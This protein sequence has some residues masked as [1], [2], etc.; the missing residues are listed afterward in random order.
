MALNK[1]Q[2]EEL[3]YEA[4]RAFSG[5]VEG[6]GELGFRVVSNKGVSAIVF[7]AGNTSG[8][9][10]EIAVCDNRLTEAYDLE[11][12][13]AW[14]DVIRA[15]EGRRCAPRK[16]AGNWPTIGFDLAG[17]SSFFRQARKLRFGSLPA[18]VIAQ[19][20][21]GKEG[22]TPE[23][24]R[25]AEARAELASRRPTKRN[26][27]I[28]L[29]RKAGVSTERWSIRRDGTLVASPRSNPNYCY[30]WAFGGKDEPALACL[31]HE[32]LTVDAGR[33]KFSGNLRQAAAR[34]EAI[35]QTAGEDSSVRKRAREQAGRAKQLDALIQ[36][37]AD[38][39][40]PL[41]VIVNEGQ[42]RSEENLGKESSVVK[43][44]YLDPQ[45]WSVEF[46]DAG[47]GDF[48]VVR[49]DRQVVARQVE[50]RE[51]P[52]ESEQ[53]GGVGDPI[54]GAQASRAF[55]DQH[56]APGSDQATRVPLSGEAYIRD[57][58]VRDACLY[59]AA[60]HC[61]FCNAPG[62]R[63]AD[64]RTYLETHH[65]VPLAEGGADREWN[66]VALCPNDHREAHYGERSR[67]IR[68]EMQAFLATVYAASTNQGSEGSSAA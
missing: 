28:D 41:R 45:S 59:R 66:V 23:Q 36:A 62:F 6:L 46:Y 1:G 56:S 25:D 19:L 7:W 67:Q 8:N 55:V 47:I 49:Q 26:A 21:V 54:P 20:R 18:D 12:V 38:R 24:V 42:M 52:Q 11:T 57:R 58:K 15:S 35:A 2:K 40:K 22:R 61:E 17:A 44:R 27:V 39:E 14:I 60:G 3:E 51:V 16:E 4:V 68:T 9:A 33:I 10:A 53:G 32:S 13:Q 31:W 5:K 50:I 43:V 34:L 30:N 29:V 48:V 64:G 37:C 63:T 65:V